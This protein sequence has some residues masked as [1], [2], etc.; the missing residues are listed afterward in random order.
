MYTAEEV[1]MMDMAVNPDVFSELPGE[2]I[3]ETDE[4]GCQA[5]LSWKDRHRGLKPVEDLDPLG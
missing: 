2:I 5:Q 4:E 3:D 1:V